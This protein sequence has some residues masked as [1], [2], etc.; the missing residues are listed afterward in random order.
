[1]SVHWP[2][3]R[4]ALRR[5]SRVAIIDDRRRWKAIELLAGAMR[6]AEE[7]DRRTTR[8]HVGVMLPA[9]GAF[10]MAAL[11]VWWLGKTLVPLN[12]LL[13]RDE[14]DYVV[15]DSEADLIVTSE[16]LLEHLD[17]PPRNAAL[18]RLEDVSFKG[19]PEPR[20]PALAAPEDIAVIL[21]TSGTSG[22]PKGVILTHDNLAS[23]VRQVIDWVDFTPDDVILGVL[24]QFHSFGLTVL[25]LLPLTRGCRTI[26]SA[27]FMPQRIVKL[28]REHR[29]TVFVGL[30]S[31]FNALLSV[32][33]AHA[34]DFASLRYTVSGGEPLPDAV[35]E[36]FLDRFG[37]AIHEGYGLT[38][39]SPV[40]NWCRPQ[41]FIRHSV[42]KPLPRVDERIV[43]PAS[44]LTLP[45]DHDG[46]VRIK[47][48]NVMRGYFKLPAETAA[49]F[50]DEGYFRT[51]D[52][53]RFDNEGR[54]YITGRLKEM[55]IV[56]GENVFPREIEEVLNR[57]RSIN[58][59]GVI[60]V[61]DGM[62]GETPVAF[63]EL[64]EGAT[65]DEPAL[66]TWCRDNLANYKVP[67][68]IIH[69]ETLPRNPTGKVLRREL[70]K[71]LPAEMSEQSE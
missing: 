12:F 31:M 55:M 32:K 7:I 54:L 39:T 21:Y 57:H 71:M 53:G 45:P 26:Y 43:D 41:E 22:R 30:P 15:K 69:L 70:K 19:L 33:D 28:F 34:E 50:D 56:G 6:L 67:R 18:L 5:P 52:I 20:W 37:V 65:F 59:S 66:R 29:P 38:E 17:A 10:P 8:P 61:P 2:I 64:N 16:A 1:M 40:T 48:P 36:R 42:G 35:F 13:R 49:A 60:G 4:R 11:A 14:L 9:T 24:P 3:V 68:R 58:A 46:E 51:G 47:G 62:R 63:V 27:R 23:N 25:T 44:G